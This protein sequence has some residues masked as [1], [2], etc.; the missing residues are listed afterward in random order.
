MSEKGRLV[1]IGKRE[2]LSWVSN[3][4]EKELSW[5][6]FSDGELILNLCFIVWP[7]LVN[8]KTGIDSLSDH[9]RQV[10][11]IFRT[12]SIDYSRLIDEDGIKSNRLSSIYNALIIFFFLYH[13]AFKRESSFEFI[14]PPDKQIAEFLMGDSSVKSLI[15]GGSLQLSPK[16]QIRLFETD[17]RPKEVTGEQIVEKHFSGGAYYDKIQRFGELIEMDDKMIKLSDNLNIF[18]EGLNDKLGELNSEK[19]N[20]DGNNNNEFNIKIRR[21]IEY[22]VKQLVRTKEEQAIERESYEKKINLM[23]EECEKRID[24]LKLECED[25]IREIES[26]YKN[27]LIQE[28]KSSQSMLRVLQNNQTLN[29]QISNSVYNNNTNNENESDNRCVN[30]ISDINFNS[31]NQLKY[32][33]EIMKEE[34]KKRDEM[35]KILNEE[36]KSYKTEN[37]K[38]RSI[39]FRYITDIS[40]DTP[41]FERITSLNDQFIKIYTMAELW[42]KKIS[43]DKNNIQ[44][45]IDI[46]YKMERMRTDKILGNIKHIIDRYQQHPKTLNKMG[47][48]KDKVSDSGFDIEILVQNN[49]LVNDCLK[50]MCDLLSDTLL[51][52]NRIDQLKEFI[53]NT[54]AESNVKK[55]LE[56]ENNCYCDGSDTFGEVYGKLVCEDEKRQLREKVRQLNHEKLLLKKGIEYLNKK[57]YTLKN[58]KL[59]LSQIDNNGDLDLMSAIENIA[60][61][62]CEN[63]EDG[64]IIEI[65]KLW[66]M[67]SYLKEEG[68]NELNIMSEFMAITNSWKSLISRITSEENYTDNNECKSPFNEIVTSDKY[69]IVEILKSDFT[70]KSIGIVPFITNSNKLLEIA[71]DYGN[72]TDSNVFGN[73]KFP[74]DDFDFESDFDRE[75]EIISRM[76]LKKEFGK[77]ITSEEIDKFPLSLKKIEILFWKLVTCLHVLREEYEMIHNH[78]RELEIK[79]GLII[80]KMEE[81]KTFYL[82]NTRECRERYE[83][84]IKNV[85][86]QLLN[87]IGKLKAE[88]SLSKIKK[89]SEL[90]NEGVNGTIESTMMEGIKNSNIII[91]SLSNALEISNVYRYIYE[92]CDDFWSDIICTIKDNINDDDKEKINRILNQMNGVKD[93]LRDYMEKWSDS[94]EKDIGEYISSKIMEIRDNNDIRSNTVNVKMSNF[95]KDLAIRNNIPLDWMHF[96]ELLVKTKTLE[97]NGEITLLNEKI[98]S[99]QNIMD[100]I[101]QNYTEVSNLNNQNEFIIEKM[102]SEYKILQDKLNS[103]IT[104]NE[105]LRNN[106]NMIK[107]KFKELDIYYTKQLINSNKKLNYLEKIFMLSIKYGIELS[108]F[109]DLYF[110][111]SDGLKEDKT[112]I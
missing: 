50:V 21:C 34:N 102:N 95:L 59:L 84:E 63:N 51:K 96:M 76:A 77:K 14:P 93:Y 3:V 10:E 1:Q 5:N 37:R 2:L 6:D 20:I 61:N 109:K 80:N 87:E 25:K 110:I 28:K 40:T 112:T 101:K 32:L 81:E 75:V 78:C 46:N 15:V 86:S 79:V 57:I 94:K 45:R 42:W 30:D 54:R 74:L 107:N 55:E 47:L 29:L 53:M 35:E 52:S 22:C 41:L 90:M 58:Q 108:N 17:S 72:I 69:N 39:I 103:L 60:S 8:M 38:L 19:A 12:L 56:E 13:C 48:D 65:S 89:S 18:F 43:G 16:T 83:Y 49:N 67:S 71:L 106:G 100:E 88:V 111:N 26:E 31:Q 98:N 62:S 27:K 85:R 91:N 44:E 92:V 9:W 64:D 70:V 33:K 68:I 73:G 7:S 105:N 66:E 97:L 11:A 82:N 23:E 24:R 36:I 99:Q 4:F 104:E